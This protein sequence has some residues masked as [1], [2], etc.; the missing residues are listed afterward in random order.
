MRD[1]LMMIMTGSGTENDLRLVLT[2]YESSLYDDDYDILFAF[3]L[4]PLCSLL[5]VT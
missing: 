2:T 1:D 5:P 4:M 3:R